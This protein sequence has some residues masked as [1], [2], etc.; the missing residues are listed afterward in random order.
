ME[1]IRKCYFVHVSL[2]FDTTETTQMSR[3]KS[4]RN[5]VILS[6]ICVIHK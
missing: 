4:H 6:F 3:G 2:G 5:S 1:I